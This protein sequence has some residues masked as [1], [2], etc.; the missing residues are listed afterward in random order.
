[1]S[2]ALHESHLVAASLPNGRT[3]AGQVSHST[4][5]MMAH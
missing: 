2:S 1:M 4:I 5:P 3:Y